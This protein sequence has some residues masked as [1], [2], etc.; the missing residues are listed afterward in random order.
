MVPTAVVCAVVR[1]K[2]RAPPS[3]LLHLAADGAGNDYAFALRCHRRSVLY[4]EVCVKG[5]S[6]GEDFV[7]PL[8]CRGGS[9]ENNQRTT[10]KF[11]EENLVRVGSPPS[12]P[13]A[14]LPSRT[15]Q[16][17][18]RL[19]AW[20]RPGSGS[21]QTELCLRRR[22]WREERRAGSLSSPS[23]PRR[24]VSKDADLSEAN[25]ERESREV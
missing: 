13:P 14:G 1:P 19:L 11:C 23:I 3:R 12:T 6:G 20:T 15:I 16:P 24:I 25:R 2:R 8:F 9:G 4:W 18:S 22:S 5:R 21:R 17:P 7:L 10:R